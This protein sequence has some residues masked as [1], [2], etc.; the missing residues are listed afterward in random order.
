MSVRDGSTFAPSLNLDD[1]GNGE[2]PPVVIQKLDMC[3]KLLKF[4]VNHFHDVPRMARKDFCRH[5]F[6]FLVWICDGCKHPP[7]LMPRTKGAFYLSSSFSHLHLSP[8]RFHT[9]RITRSRFVLHALRATR[10]TRQPISG[11]LPLFRVVR[12][13][14]EAWHSTTP[15]RV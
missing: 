3:V 14:G 1:V 15:L 7:F 4:G 9:S 11:S 2:P 12:P 6:K 8:F 13:S 5:N 10:L